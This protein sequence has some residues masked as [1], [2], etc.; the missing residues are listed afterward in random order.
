MAD[1]DLFSRWCCILLLAVYQQIE[2][3][4][5]SGRSQLE[6]AD[7]SQVGNLISP[8]LFAIEVLQ[9]LDS[10]TKYQSG[11]WSTACNV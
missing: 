10:V 8:T 9:V 1:A 3:A 7:W 6:H 5:A 4:S 11:C 2:P